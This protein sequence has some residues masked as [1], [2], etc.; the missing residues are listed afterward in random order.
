MYSRATA[1][2]KLK[3]DKN[4]EEFCAGATRFVQKYAEGGGVKMAVQHA[5]V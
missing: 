2:H 1:E 3:F 5:T 4:V